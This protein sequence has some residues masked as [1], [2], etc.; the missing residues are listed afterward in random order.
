MLG[1]A[2]LCLIAGVVFFTRGYVVGRD[3]PP[4]NQ[5]LIDQAASEAVIKEAST[6]LVTVFSY[7]YANPGA[8]QAAADD[9]LVGAARK[10]FDVLL[11]TMLEEA[12][13]QKLTLSAEVSASGVRNLTDDTAELLVFL[14]QRSERS[15][16]A[17]VTVSAAM[18][19]V[20]L[21]RVGGAWRVE[22][23]EM[24]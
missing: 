22:N 13:G 23:F 6:A 10:E 9:F 16:D 17:E 14:D 1:L 3:D 5:A 7:D 20:Q 11:T 4:E 21:R 2:V 8:I 18:L 12:P 15:T 19:T 24:L